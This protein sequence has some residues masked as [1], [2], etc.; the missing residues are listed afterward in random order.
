MKTV[1]YD[2]N[3]TVLDDV[4]TCLVAINTIINEYLDREPLDA[5]SYRE[6]FCF[7]VKEYYEKVGFD[8]DVLSFADLGARWMA[9]YEANKHLYKLHEGIKDQLITNKKNDTR[10]ILLSASEINMLK[11]QCAELGIS[12]LFDEILGI[13]DIYAASKLDIAKAW[14]AKENGGPYIFIGDSLHDAEVAKAIN[15]PCALVAKGH[16]SR[17]ILETSG[18]H[19]YDD[20]REVVNDPDWPV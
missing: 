15:I 13:D 1:I 2:F 3:G 20:I 16:Q 8:F 6:L 9:V 19:V 14:M 18:L 12:D 5:A 10:N 7:P 17:N 11:G 4:A